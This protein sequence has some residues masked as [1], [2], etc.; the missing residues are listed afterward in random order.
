MEPLTQ[1]IFQLGPCAFFSGLDAEPVAAA[2]AG[3]QEA[4]RYYTPHPVFHYNASGQQTRVECGYR[5]TEAWDSVAVW[6]LRD[7]LKQEC[8]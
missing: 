2:Y 6:R 8:P 5:I 4:L 3:N 7:K 1:R